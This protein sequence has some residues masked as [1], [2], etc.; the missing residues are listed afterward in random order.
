MIIDFNRTVAYI[1]P[2]CGEVAYGEFSLFGLSGGRGLTVSCDCGKSSLKFLC[3]GGTTYSI[4]V[5][6]QV[7]EKEHEY[8]ISLSELMHK[9]FL[10]FSCPELLMSLV[11]IGEKEK[12]EYSVEENISVEKIGARTGQPTRDETLNA[13]RQ[14]KGG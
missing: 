7:C 2:G 4:S 14:Q 10:E 6:C 12:I 11:F 3:K 8:K 9:S 1:C 13:L 5:G